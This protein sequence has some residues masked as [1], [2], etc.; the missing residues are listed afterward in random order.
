M[1]YVLAAIILIIIASA[2]YWASAGDIATTSPR[3]HQAVKAEVIDSAPENYTINVHSFS[4]LGVDEDAATFA[5]YTSSR[6][7]KTCG[8]FSDT[9]LS[10]NKPE[11]YERRF[12]LSKNP[13][14]LAAIEQY[15]CVVIPNKPA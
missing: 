11:K 1:R 5:V 9:D 13:E 3:N 4:N 2:P 15:Q 6:L 8:D 14:I 12:D 7:P 10:Y